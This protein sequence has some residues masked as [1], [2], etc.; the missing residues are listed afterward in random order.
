[1]TNVLAGET[2]W[3]HCRFGEGTG[4]L[5]FGTN[6][7]GGN[8]AL[9]FDGRLTSTN[10]FLNGVNL[11]GTGT[12]Y[13]VLTWI[14]GSLAQGDGAPTI[15]P[16]GVLVLAGS[17]GVDYALS[18]ALYNAGTIKMVS[19][20]LPLNFCGSGKGG[21]INEPGGLVD[22]EAD[23]SIDS[24]CDGQINNEGIV[25][26]S[27]GTGTTDIGAFFN[28][29][30]GI[31]DAQTGAIGLTNNYNLTGGTLNFG[32]SSLASYGRIYLSSIDALSGNLS[33]NLNNGYAPTNGN[34][35]PLVT[36]ASE[37]G[38]FTGM[39]LPAWINW[40]TSYSSTTLTLT[41]SNLDGRPV[42]AAAPI[43]APGQF[44]LQFAGNPNGSYSLLATTNLALPVADWTVLGPATLISN[45]LFGFVDQH[46]TNDPCRFYMLRSP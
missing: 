6:I 24:P 40:L 28:N 13:G 4:A 27:G 32:I 23:V 31:L 42:L 12:N 22:I 26:K 34:A 15:A 1:M 19:G 7:Y 35:F 30:A 18:A 21:I 43:P 8:N 41:V 2:H 5:L 38:A 39:T 9:T 46:T 20:N 45:D 10:A 3:L 25:R 33:V 17:N 11:V 44:S 16:Q 36:Y 29:G 14:S 37:H